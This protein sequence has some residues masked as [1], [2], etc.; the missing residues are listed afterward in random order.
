MAQDVSLGAA[1]VAATFG[2]EPVEDAAL[3]DNE[4]DEDV[5]TVAADMQSLS[6]IQRKR[7]ERRAAYIRKIGM[8]VEDKKKSK[9]L[10][11]R[12]KKTLSG[13]QR[14]K[15][16]V[17]Y[18]GQAANQELLQKTNAAKRKRAKGAASMDVEA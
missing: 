1:A 17:E 11:D 14:Q 4:A 2:D 8:A 16:A 5:E 10:K 3:A 7:L 18:R 15:L 12:K 6:R 9:S 13:H